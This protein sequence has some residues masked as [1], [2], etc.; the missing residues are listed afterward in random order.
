MAAADTLPG[1]TVFLN[2]E[3]TPREPADQVLARVTPAE[4]RPGQRTVENPV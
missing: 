4:T 2:G 3:L 1:D